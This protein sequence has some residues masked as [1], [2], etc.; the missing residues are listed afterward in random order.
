MRH[1]NTPH[2]IYIKVHE[3]CPSP[4]LSLM[5]YYKKTCLYSSG[6]KLIHNI[7]SYTNDNILSSYLY[8]ESANLHSISVISTLKIILPLD[9]IYHRGMLSFLSLS[10]RSLEVIL[11][12]LKRTETVETS[13]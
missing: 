8:Y 9:F 1:D 2:S 13:S 11:V 4:F 7:L 6:R 5:Q 3:K 12:L 10:L